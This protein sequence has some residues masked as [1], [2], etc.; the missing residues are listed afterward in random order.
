LE[1]KVKITIERY[2]LIEKD[3]KI[4]VAVSG[5]PDSLSLLNVL[6]N[7]GYNLCVAHVNHGLRENA[8]GDEKFVESF[9]QE[10][11][12][13]CFIKKINLK[14]ILN[15]MSTEEA[16]RKERYD[17][18]DE[19]CQ[20]ENCTKIATAHN[21]NDNVETVI[22]NMIRGSGL[23]GLKGIEPKRGNIIRPLIEISRN[24][25]EEYCKENNLTPRHDESNDET[26]YTRNKVRIELIPYIEKNIN[27][28]VINNITR[29]S[30]IISDEERFILE[31]V[32][33]A[34]NDV[35]LKEEE[36][37]VICDLKVFNKLDVVLKRRLI[38]KMIIKVLGNAKD[39]EKVHV[40]DVVKLCQN[41]VGGK[42]LTPNKNIK[43]SVLQG[44]LKFEKVNLKGGANEKTI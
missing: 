12:I 16:G 44:K 36:N 40:D 43:I 3:D 15:G 35:V 19:I 34:Y 14:E 37:K 38:L 29:M 24:E 11:R 27:S 21:S 18:F 17:F 5:G 20:K 2:N 13:P 32:E 10:K 6:Q 22:M 26:I 8:N 31:M 25:I 42:F 1:N 7:L 30:Q 28:N 23:S 39:I 41:N 9:C 4:L 33:N